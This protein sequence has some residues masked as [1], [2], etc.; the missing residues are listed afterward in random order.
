MVLL[1]ILRKGLLD[2]KIRLRATA[3][4]APDKEYKTDVL[5]E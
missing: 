1:D 2:R 4:P 3:S 5:I